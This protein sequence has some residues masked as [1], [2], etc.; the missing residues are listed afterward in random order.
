MSCSS[1]AGPGVMLVGD[2]GHATSPSLGQ[3]CNAALEDVMIMDKVRGG[4][5]RNNERGQGGLRNRGKE[6]A[7]RRH[8]GP[9]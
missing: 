1:L 5:A 9:W 8:V 4:D 3:G 7:G 2:A 6:E